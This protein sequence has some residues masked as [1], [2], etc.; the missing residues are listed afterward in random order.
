[1]IHELYASLMRAKLTNSQV[2][3]STVWLG[4]SPRYYSNLLATRRE[5]GVATLLEFNLRLLR[6]ALNSDWGFDA[7]V[8]L[9]LRD[10]LNEEISR[11]TL[12]QAPLRRSLRRSTFSFCTWG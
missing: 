3:F 11:R 8:L 12:L 7:R 5:P 6:V 4:R 1:M 10:Q 9:E 2:H